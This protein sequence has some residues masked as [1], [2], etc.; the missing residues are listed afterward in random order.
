MCTFRERYL[1]AFTD[2]INQILQTVGNGDRELTQ[3]DIILLR[4]YKKELQLYEKKPQ[5]LKIAE[6]INA[7][8]SSFS[9]G[10]KQ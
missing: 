2:T 6:T 9:G 5:H 1:E 3:T 10:D 8:F 4:T 7:V